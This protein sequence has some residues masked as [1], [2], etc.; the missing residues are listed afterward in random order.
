V[1]RIRRQTTHEIDLNRL[2]ARLFCKNG[3]ATS[4]YWSLNQ[5]SPVQTFMRLGVYCMAALEGTLGGIS[6]L[7]APLFVKNI[8]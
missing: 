2:H 6:L 8:A 4:L 5:S 1:T 3:T 7:Y